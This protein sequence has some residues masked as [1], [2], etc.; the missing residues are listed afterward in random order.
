MEKL[1]E[2]IFQIRG[3][4]YKPVES[5][6]K[7][8]ENYV[9]LLRA[10]NINNGKINFENLVYVKREK[11]KEIQFL[12]KGDILICTSSGSKDLVGKAGMIR[13][14]VYATFGAFCKVLRLKA[15]CNNYYFNHYF[16]SDYYKS[17]IQKSS[18]GANINNLKAENFDELSVK[19]LSYDEQNNI[20]SK[21]DKVQEMIDIRKKQIN[22]LDMLIKSQ[23][24]EHNIFNKLGVA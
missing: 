8:K 14:D 13:E 10:N 18:N 6:D 12:K 22:E 7:Y 11:V 19:V 3:V 16:Q 20:A 15:G 17:M 4:S 24:V 23:F 1:K 9:P 5:S 2:Y 21:L